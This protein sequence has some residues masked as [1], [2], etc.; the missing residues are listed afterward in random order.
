MLCA[1][2]SCAFRAPSYFACRK[3]GTV[4]HQVRSS[5]CRQQPLSVS[6]PQFGPLI[7]LSAGRDARV[8]AQA[9]TSQ[10][11]I[12]D[13]D[14]DVVEM[15]LRYC[16]GCLQE[17]P[18][19]HSQVGTSAHATNTSRLYPGLRTFCAELCRLRALRVRPLDALELRA[20]KFQ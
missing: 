2:V 13:L 3:A 18:S 4:L 11:C 10:V 1:S 20:I 14:P 15:L 16:Y 17:L 6:T 12:S 5:L 19:D 9:E 8:G 7:H